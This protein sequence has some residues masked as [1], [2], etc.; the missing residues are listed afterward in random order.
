MCFIFYLYLLLYLTL[1]PLD[2]LSIIKTFYSQKPARRCRCYQTKDTKQNKKKISVDTNLCYYFFMCLNTHLNYWN[3][4]GKKKLIQREKLAETDTNKKTNKT[5]SRWSNSRIAMKLVRLPHIFDVVNQLTDASARSKQFFS[6][7]CWLTIFF[8]LDQTRHQVLRTILAV[9]ACCTVGLN[10]HKR[11]NEEE[12]L[13]HTKTIQIHARI[14]LAFCKLAWFSVSLD[15]TYYKKCLLLM[16]IFQDRHSIDFWM[17][18]AHGQWFQHQAT[19]LL[20]DEWHKCLFIIL[21]W[22]T[23]SST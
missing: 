4:G 2:R 14:R 15:W 18:Q 6:D 16:E 21:Y 19:N 20:N 17:F 23:S 8:L 7:G 13:K 11:E 1:H 12:R 10:E 5:G 22:S 9:V 3:K